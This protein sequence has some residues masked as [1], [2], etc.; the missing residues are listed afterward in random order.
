MSESREVAKEI[1]K[2]IISKRNGE[3]VPPAKKRGRPKK[4]QPPV[5]TNGSCK[6]DENGEVTEVISLAVKSLPRDVV[7]SAQQY[8]RE[9]ALALVGLY[10]SI[11][12]VRMGA[13]NRESAH[14][15]NVDILSDP[16]LIT[17]LKNE[18]EKV[19]GQ[20]ERGLK[21][22]AKSQPLGRWAMMNLGV[23][24]I[25][26]AAFLAHIDLQRCCCPNWIHL[27]GGDRKEIP[28]H[29]CLGLRTAGRIYKFAGLLP[30]KE[31]IWEKGMRRPYNLRLKVQWYRMGCCWKRSTVGKE[32]LALVTDDDFR[33]YIK[34]RSKKVLTDEQVE[35]RIPVEK[36]SIQDDLVSI[37][38]EG[39]LYVRLYQQRK[40]LE[41][42]MNNTGK[43]RFAAKELLEECLQRRAKISP[44]QKA[45]WESGKLQDVGLDRR[46]IRYAVKIFFSHWH[47]V[48][49]H[50]LG[51]PEVVPYIMAHGGHTGYISPPFFNL[52]KEGKVC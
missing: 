22:F 21:E 31:L 36:K 5:H 4:E 49:R 37:S 45:C 2:S 33:N 35:T 13:R 47:T 12:K 8:T 23:G 50:L 15:R 7:Q 44:E 39:G 48:G 20:A 41:T 51:L 10:E 18:L 14:E 38:G 28:P 34:S 40:V 11:Q 32:R 24:P 3:A 19:E 30:K 9:Q 26:T 52:V 25:C 43:L 6:G 1:A 27:K 42:E 16:V 17:S 46:A 29:D